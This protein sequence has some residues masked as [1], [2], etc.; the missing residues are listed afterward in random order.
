M[1]L[2]SD[3]LQKVDS[4]GFAV[5]EVCVLAGVSPSTIAVLR[6]Q[7]TGC[8]QRTYDLMICALIKMVQQRNQNMIEA[9]LVHLDLINSADTEEA[10]ARNRAREATEEEQGRDE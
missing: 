6:R 8:S 3:L 4:A 10:L 2:A 1:N 5:K 9:H 7:K